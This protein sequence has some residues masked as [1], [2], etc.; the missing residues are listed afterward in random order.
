MSLSV[1][2]SNVPTCSGNFH[3]RDKLFSLL[4]PSFRLVLI[5][6]DVNFS[7]VVGSFQNSNLVLEPQELEH[8]WHGPVTWAGGW[9]F[10]FNGISMTQAFQ[11]L[12]L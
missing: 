10:Y 11:I 1:D 7:K 3:G 9:F 8:Y 6:E 2:V 12:M 4:A 5:E